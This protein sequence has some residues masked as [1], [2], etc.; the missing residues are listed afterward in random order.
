MTDNRNEDG[1]SDLQQAVEARADAAD[2]A[3]GGD[4][5]SALEPTGVFDGNSGTGGEVKNQDRTQ[6]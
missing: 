3:E 6:Q 2:A 5:S 4:D 1:R